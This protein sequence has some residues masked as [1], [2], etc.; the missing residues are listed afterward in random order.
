MKKLTIDAKR[1]IVL[2]ST[3]FL[4]FSLV[5]AQQ[6]SIT[7]TPSSTVICSGDLAS[8]TASVSPSYLWSDG[9][10]TNIIVV[11]PTVTTTYSVIGTDSLGNPDTAIQTITVNP[12]PII[13]ITASATTI[14]SGQSVM[15]ND[16]SSSKPSPHGPSYS[17]S[18]GE[19]T[20][21]IIVTPTFTTTYTVTFT[22]A[23]TCSGSATQVITVNPIP[24]ISITSPGTSSTYCS[25]NSITLGAQDANN[26]N[27]TYVWSDGETTDSITVIP[28]ATTTYSVTLT[29]P[30][31]CIGSDSKVITVVPTPVIYITATATS[32][33]LGSSVTLSDPIVGIT[34]PPPKGSTYKWSNGA[35]TESI[36]VS[37]LVTSIYSVIFTTP[38]GCR[39][40]ASQVIR[41][42]PLP[43]IN[44]STT[45]ATICSGNSSL[46]TA[47]GA[48]TYLWSDGE[49][50]S[51]IN[52]SPSV[53]TTYSVTGVDINGCSNTGSLVITV[54]PAP[55]VSITASATTINPGS[56]VSL[57]A[58]G[59]SSYVW[60]SSTS[61][62]SS[63]GA[64]ITATPTVTTTYTVT[65][66]STLG[67]LATQTVIINVNTGPIFINPASATICAGS[68]VS[69]SATGGVNYSWSTGQH[70]PT[71]TV[72]PTVTTKY[73]V[74]GTVNHTSAQ[75][76]VVVN[77]N[78]LPTISISPSA[79]GVCSGSPVTLTASGGDTYLWNTGATTNTITV[80][81][82]TSTS[83]SVIGT[84]S[85][86]GCS[87]TATINIPITPLPTVTIDASSKTI[88]EGSSVMLTANGAISYTWNDGETTSSIVV[89]PTTSTTYTVTGTA[90][91][92]CSNSAT[93][94]ISVNPSP[95]ISITSTSDSVSEWQKD[96]LTASTASNYLWNSGATTKS[97][98]V[99]P[100]VSVMYNVT[101]TAANG[102]VGSDNKLIYRIVNS[103]ECYGDV[104]YQVAVNGNGSSTFSIT[105]TQSDELIVIWTGGI[106]YTSNPP[107]LQTAVKV[108]GN[109]ATLLS[110]SGSSKLGDLTLY[111]YAYLA[112][113]AKLHT[114]NVLSDGNI[115]FGPP[116]AWDNFA[117]AFY[118]QNSCLP[119]NIKSCYQVPEVSGKGTLSTTVKTS[120]PN[121]VIFSDFLQANNAGSG[122]YIY[123]WVP[124]NGNLSQYSNFYVSYSPYDMNSSIIIPYTPTPGNNVITCGNGAPTTIE[125]ILGNVVIQPPLCG[126]EVSTTP[127]NPTVSPCTAGSI[128]V[129]VKGGNPP[130]SYT[131]SP[132]VSSNAS[133]SGLSPGT[134]TITVSDPG[135]PACAAQTVVVTLTSPIVVT[136]GNSTICSG[137]STTLTA[138][139]ATTYTWAPSA[140][141]NTTTGSSV[142]A[143]PQ[144]TTIYTV[145][146]TSGSC[147]TTATTTVNVMQTNIYGPSAVCG[148]IPTY[149]QGGKSQEGA[150]CYYTLTYTAS[151]SGCNGTPTYLWTQPAFTP[152]TGWM[153]KASG[154]TVTITL[155]TSTDYMDINNGF[156]LTC[157]GCCNGTCCTQ[158][159]T[160][161]G[162]C[163][164]NCANIVNIDLN[165]GFPAS[166][167]TELGVQHIY[168]SGGTWNIS[169]VNTAY[170]VACL[171]ID[172][173]LKV[174]NN[175]IISNSDIYFGTNAEIDIS[176]NA[177]L[178][179][180]NCHL[181]ACNY[182][183]NG[184]YVPN[185]SEVDVIDGS[186]VEDA[187]S[188]IVSI[189]G[190]NYDIENSTLNKDYI[191]ITVQAFAGTHPGSIRGSEISCNGILGSTPPYNSSKRVTINASSPALLVA[192]YSGHRSSTGIL[193]NSV[194]S[195]TIGNPSIPVVKYANYF[196]NLDCGINSNASG[197]TIVNNDFSDMY[198]ANG[199]NK[200]AFCSGVYANGG[201]ISTNNLIVGGT[202][203]SDRNTFTNCMNGLQ[204]VNTV[205]ATIENNA[206]NGPTFTAPNLPNG[207]YLLANQHGKISITQNTITNCE[208]GIYS[209]FNFNASITI[210]TNTITGSPLW[211]GIPSGGIVIQETPVT[212]INY[213][214]NGN[215]ISAVDNG[216]F[217]ENL[218]GHTNI[219]NNKITID[220]LGNTS[221]IQNEGIYM[222]NST[223]AYIDDNHIYGPGLSHTIGEGIRLDMGN[224]N[225][226]VLCN[227]IHHIATHLAFESPAV[228]NTTVDNNQMDDY[229]VGLYLNNN[230]DIGTQGSATHGS[231]NEWLT[232]GFSTYCNGASNITGTGTKIWVTSLGS[233]NTYP[234]YP[235]I[236][237]EGA[238]APSQKI[239]FQ[240]ST[241]LDCD[242]CG[243]FIPNYCVIHI[244]P[245]QAI[246]IINNSTL[247]TSYASPTH[248]HTKH[249]LYKYLTQADS[250][251]VDSSTVIRNFVDSSRKANVGGLEKINT[252]L[253]DSMGISA[254]DVS[255]AQT[256]NNALVNP[257][258]VE[259][260]AQAVYKVILSMDSSSFNMPDSNEVKTLEGIAPL[261]P[262]QY[263][264]GV[265]MARALLSLVSNTQ[266]I[267]ACEL[268]PS[269]N[270]QPEIAKKRNE[271]T[272]VAPLV[273]VY[274]NPANTLLNIA[275]N[276]SQVQSPTVCIFN[277]MGE[278]I[279]C[280]E[281]TDN[282]TAIS[283][284][285][286]AQGMYYYRITNANGNLIKADKVMVM[287]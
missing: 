96:T 287:H 59:A 83:Y 86:V 161:G 214:I 100:D 151:M 244:N 47:S 60:M 144:T 212:S 32:I 196:E 76:T 195:I 239:P 220:G 176:S 216:I 148:G 225:N 101:T 262:V 177:K 102:C 39:A 120:I 188:A 6:S 51:T 48:S 77:V 79:K 61:L 141:L 92:E 8:L 204:V 185:G 233:P 20:D 235:G 187:K 135:A 199:Y 265:Y 150:V 138:S 24:I 210:N 146:G 184:I 263:G 73:T 182:M 231:A 109:Y 84:D 218:W 81:P 121:S 113:V 230:S 15:L 133:A 274:P 162:C 200:G 74:T 128:N 122:P 194:N 12:L 190:G 64:T 273:E 256:L 35:S 124:N 271:S 16:A 251:L 117:A 56:S 140:G 174:D 213:T 3:F 170:N 110:T 116:Y 157:E 29:T 168:K 103:A 95:T 283:T 119:L 202:S 156:T 201:G 132:N 163:L 172:G 137:S 198:F 14:C 152:G 82:T 285:T 159:F 136:G 247:Y 53:T 105:T 50:T 164:N 221:K 211:A 171:E 180:E 125:D 13:S 175:L 280:L 112:P 203:V 58:D 66:E 228:P 166:I 236:F 261:C 232:P 169:D 55:S 2:F 237:T 260:T 118:V 270:G 4:T 286:L 158:T 131:W 206:I 215:Q 245:L 67:C 142:I 277:M 43:V 71:I 65:G 160:V 153:Y 89:V 63:K 114:I 223:N 108:D 126:L 147:S 281:L 282:I 87:N 134:Y 253:S 205:N 207:I 127:T 267:S 242:V 248:W 9:E 167:I 25:G 78:Q 26:T 224:A 123:T 259:A 155:P 276:I 208:E 34:G 80:N 255:T 31:G 192:P 38:Q 62:N 229:N 104:T 91:S 240:M 36:T 49:T 22:D 249:S 57:T 68:S 266:Y 69:L 238:I 257:D 111:A 52:V 243:N 115:F 143:S 222:A 272:A 178:T 99:S 17:W 33:C 226:F 241:G 197:A 94:A 45:T 179:I 88:C 189:D 72:A 246:A 90:N 139:G 145:T 278:Q 30:E 44:V 28:A 41:V 5:K 254:A 11:T 154:N 250:S 191:G 258:T 75:Q 46:L 106:Y 209:V 107:S 219:V 85:K 10:T 97:I 193:I 7:I 186:L 264:Y 279:K 42:N 165:S 70:G 23:N 130:Y 173:V 37:P 18:D 21:T 183:W 1:F 181:H 275:L 252:L 54:S 269:V 227:D 19:T 27:S 234:Y 268:L 40:R 149:C 217:T 284:S 129:S 93:V 98:V